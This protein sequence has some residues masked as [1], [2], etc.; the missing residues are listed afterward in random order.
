MKYEAKQIMSIIFLE[1]SNIE[2]DQIDP[3]GNRRVK[4]VILNFPHLQQIP[5]RPKPVMS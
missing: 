4:D 5:W 1:K 2:W 3:K